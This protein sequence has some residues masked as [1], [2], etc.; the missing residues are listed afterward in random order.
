MSLTQKVHQLLEQIPK[1]K[2]TT[3]KYI[4]LKLNTKAYRA[5]GSAIGKNINSQKRPCHRV[6][7]SDGF[8]GEFNLGKGKKIELLTNEGFIIKDDKI[9]NFEKVLYKFEE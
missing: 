9:Q 2:V 6:V 1:G 3:Y 4:A 5:I 8:V 7:R